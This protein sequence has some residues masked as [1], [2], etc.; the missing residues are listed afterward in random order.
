MIPQS[1]YRGYF[2]RNHGFRIARRT[3]VVVDGRPHFQYG[4]FWFGL[5]DPWPENWSTN[6]YANDDVYIDYSN[7]GYYLYNRRHPGIGIAIN[8]YVD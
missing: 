4:G 6:W 2:G 3:V 8:V 5:M 7:D 1:R